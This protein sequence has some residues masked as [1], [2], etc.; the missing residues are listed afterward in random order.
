LGGRGLRRR[1]NGGDLTNEYNISLFGT[2]TMNLP[3]YN[4]YILI[5]K[6][7]KKRKKKMLN[8]E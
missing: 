8:S 6:K 3:L 1:Y 5:T 2:V 7:K 4:E